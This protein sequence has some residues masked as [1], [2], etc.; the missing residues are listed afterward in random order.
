[1]GIQNDALLFY[2]IEFSYDD[3]QHLKKM[4]KDICQTIGSDW[5]PNLWQELGFLTCSNYYDAEEEH[6][7]YIIGRELRSDM[8]CGEFF[9]ELREDDMILYLK[10]QC[11]KYN[12]KYTTPKIISR[13]NIY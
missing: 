9:N 10:Q 2:G 1:M 13:P 8:T 12:L 7:N 4:K 6:I 5:M 3:I 11:E